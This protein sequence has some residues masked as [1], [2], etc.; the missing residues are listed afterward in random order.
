MTTRKT[1]PAILAFALSLGLAAAAGAAAKSTLAATNNTIAGPGTV[2]IAA[3]ASERIFLHSGG[4]TD[5]CVTVVNSGKLPVGIAVTGATSPTGEVGAN[6]SEA[7]CAED[8]TQVDLVC[9]QEQNC[10][11]QW[12]IDD[13]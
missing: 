1:I 8:V 7:V 5:L 12:R 11:A 10:A 4:T 2:S 13:N 3:G 9:N 6:G